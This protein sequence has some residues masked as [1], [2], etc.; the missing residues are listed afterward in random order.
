MVGIVWVEVKISFC[1]VVSMF[2]LC[3]IGIIWMIG[4]II[5]FCCFSICV[6]FCDV[7]SGWVNRRV[8]VMV[9]VLFGC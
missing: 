9:F 1:V 7:V 5:V 2:V 3:V 8:G 4:E 6:N